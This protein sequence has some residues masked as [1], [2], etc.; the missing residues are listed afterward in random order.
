MKIFLEHISKRFQ[1]HWIFRDIN[2][3]FETPG[4]Y[5]LLGP[6]G[7]GKSTLLRILAGMQ[8]P[9]QGKIQF[10]F[11]GKSLDAN[12]LYPYISFCAP[13]MEIIE[14]MTLREFLSFHFTFKKSLKGLT[15]EDII[16][17]SGLEHV[18]DR[19]VSDYSSGMKQRVKLLQ[20]FFSDTPVLLLD[21]PCTNLD[22]QGVAQYI[23]WID[24][25]TAGR[26]V[27]VASNDP[28]EYAFCQ[29][30]IAIEAYQ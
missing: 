12:K 30:L 29:K 3:S 21:E 13:G 15:V 16:A 2:I 4:T 24:T 8:P 10:A 25:Y 22:A 17:A 23:T 19:L 27:I 11:R 1:R 5:A 14:E 7:S 20:A 28:R 9:S 6:N 26:L 18:A